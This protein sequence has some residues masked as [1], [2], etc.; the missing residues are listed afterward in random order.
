MTNVLAQFKDR[1][2]SRLKTLPFFTDST[3][4]SPLS[5]LVVLNGFTDSTIQDPPIKI[6]IVPHIT[7]GDKSNR[8]NKYNAV[9]HEY[10]TANG[11]VPVKLYIAIF[12]PGAIVPVDGVDVIAQSTAMNVADFPQPDPA[13]I[14]Q[15]ET[16]FVVE[17]DT[18]ALFGGS[19]ATE[20]T[21]LNVVPV[22]EYLV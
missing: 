8:L 6:D 19:A 7:I 12:A 3:K 11:N 1:I 18:T 5:K 9:V 22:L 14:T 13:L 16:S 21:G 20:I 15:P 2:L 4:R 17:V 10:P